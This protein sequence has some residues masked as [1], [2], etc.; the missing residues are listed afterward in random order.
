MLHASGKEIV[1]AAFDYPMQAGGAEMFNET[2][3]ALKEKY[4]DLI[5]FVYGMH[6]SQWWAIHESIWNEQ[7]KVEIADIVEREWL[8]NG[9]KVR[10]KG[11]FYQRP[12]KEDKQKWKRPKLDTLAA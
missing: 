10:I 2:V 6:D 1:R 5:R 4:G 8:I 9:Q 12:T 11:T 7:T 3:I